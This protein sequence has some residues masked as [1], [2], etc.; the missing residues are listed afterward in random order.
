MAQ[1]YIILENLKFNEQRFNGIVPIDSIR[2]YFRP[3]YNCFQL[4]F[5]L[6]MFINY[7]RRKVEDCIDFNKIIVKYNIEKEEILKIPLFEEL[8]RNNSEKNI[9][10]EKLFETI[11]NDDVDYLQDLLLEYE[12]NIG[13]YIYSDKNKNIF[14]FKERICGFNDN[15]KALEYISNALDIKPLTTELKFHR[16]TIDIY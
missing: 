3:L 2:L 14:I 15:D 10:I 7:R 8:I 6:G 11:I 1:D 13:E 4:Q 9:S 12:K 16:F 5:T